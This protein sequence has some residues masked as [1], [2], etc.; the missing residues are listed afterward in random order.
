[1]LIGLLKRSKDQRGFLTFTL[2]P[3]MLIIVLSVSCILIGTAFTAKKN[4]YMTHQWF[5]GAMDFASEA[6]FRD[7]TAADTA[8]RT[9]A[10]RQWFVYAFSR[11]LDAGYDGNSFTPNGRS[12][13][14]GP[15]QLVSFTYIPP[16]SPVPGGTTRQPGY[17]AVIEVPVIGGNLPF[18]GPQYVAVPMS[19]FAVLK[20]TEQEE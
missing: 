18:V 12:I 14:P 11:M 17:M 4:A 13:Y 8:T 5:G 19:Y 20:S 6:M 3:I 1:M 16:G 10:A 9:D 2:L 7:K 15:I